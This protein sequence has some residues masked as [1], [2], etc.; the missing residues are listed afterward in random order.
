MD[1]DV[2]YMKGFFQHANALER[3]LDGRRFADAILDPAVRDYF[4]GPRNVRVEVHHVVD[5]KHMQRSL[6]WILDRVHEVEK[7]VSQAGRRRV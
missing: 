7:A 4:R 6:R 1:D 3:S 5:G 2:I